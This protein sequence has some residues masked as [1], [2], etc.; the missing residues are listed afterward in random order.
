YQAHIR[1]GKAHC[2]QV[3]A[4]SASNPTGTTNITTHTGAARVKGVHVAIHHALIILLYRNPLKTPPNRTPI[5]P[6]FTYQSPTAPKGQPFSA[7][8]WYIWRNHW[9]T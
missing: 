9:P 2:T 8:G 6:K 7:R 1:S 4:V 3:T 5:Q